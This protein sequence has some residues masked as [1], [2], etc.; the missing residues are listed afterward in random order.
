MQAIIDGDI[1]VYRVGYTTEQEDWPIARW[2]MNTSIEN[3]LE[4]L[5]SLEYSIY[6]SDSTENGFRRKLF[7]AYKIHRTQPKP[8]HYDRLKEHLISEWG[9]LITLEEEADDRLGIEQ[10][11]ETVICSIDKD[12]DQ[13]VGRHYNFVKGDLYEIT[14]EQ[15]RW[16]FYMQL[17]Q[18]DR[19]DFIPGIPKI[20][21]KKAERILEGAV[22]DEDYFTRCREAYHKA[23]L[24]DLDMYLTGLL[25]KIRT[26][27]QELWTFPKTFQSLQPKMEELL[28]F[29]QIKVE[30]YKA[31]IPTVL[32][33]P[34]TTEET[35][36]SVQQ[37]GQEMVVNS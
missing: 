5:N 1:L 26:K 14:E 16:F 7:P 23:G 10:T 20:G 18:G 9:A 28:S 21:P 6:L 8:K 3:I 15:S 31:K 22:L 24:S 2:R 33:A 25:V 35:Q 27:P 32:S 13:I 19:T 11:V 37:H 34:S 17:L 36:D 30:E 29:S 12:L 4:N